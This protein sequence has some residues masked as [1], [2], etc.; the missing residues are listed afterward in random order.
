MKKMILRKTP[1]KQPGFQLKIRHTGKAG[2]F[3]EHQHNSVPRDVWSNPFD[4]FDTLLGGM[5]TFPF[6]SETFPD[7]SSILA[8]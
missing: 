8:S 3:L 1:K 5:S 4:F 7:R 2:L 6:L